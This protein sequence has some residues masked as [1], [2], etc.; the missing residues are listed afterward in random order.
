MTPAAAS[1]TRIRGGTVVTA[2]EAFV[3]DVYLTDGRVSALGTGL[4]LPVDGEI[5]AEGCLVLPGGVDPHVH[6]DFPSLTTFTADD[7]TSGTAA[8]ALGGTTTIVNFALQ[9]GGEHLLKALERSVAQAEG[10]A[11][12]DYAF[13]VVVTD[14]SSPRLREIDEI[15][16]AGAS[17]V[18]MFMAYPGELMVDD[19]TLMVVMERLAELGGLLRRGFERGR[20]R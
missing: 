9:R 11:V 12:I 10:A 14:M 5:A 4:D 6:L 3:A 13:H 19:A 18:K 16:A 8:A 2:S 1:T 15:V 17:S 20:R 7:T